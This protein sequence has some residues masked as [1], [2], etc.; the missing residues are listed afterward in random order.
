MRMT[1]IVAGVALWII[2]GP[3][4]TTPLLAPCASDTSHVATSRFMVRVALTAHNYSQ[5]GL[6][7][8]PHDS[9]LTVVTDPSVCA[10]AR[11]VLF[12]LGG[13]TTGTPEVLVLRLGGSGF[14]VEV[15]PDR[16]TTHYFTAT[17]QYLFSLLGI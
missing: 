4:G 12:A 3:P 11:A 16:D 1:L 17:W 2:A 7:F 6:P 14:A 9:T 5:Q 10:A 15:P 8:Q 13:D